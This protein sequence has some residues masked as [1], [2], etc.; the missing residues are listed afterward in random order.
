MDLQE[1]DQTSLR[2]TRALVVDDDAFFRE[3]FVD[4]LKEAGFTEPQTCHGGREVL[5][6]LHTMRPQPGLILCDLHMP[7]S[8]DGFQVM[9]GLA[10]MHY[11]GVVLLISGQQAHVL[12]SAK[13]MGRF[14]QLRVLGPVEKPVSLA[15]L[16]DMLKDIE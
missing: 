11:D 9:Q 16:Q 13:L 14:H 15:Q 3:Y 12:H 8:L 7:G 10:D 5:N 1:K 4:L 6:L 2:Q